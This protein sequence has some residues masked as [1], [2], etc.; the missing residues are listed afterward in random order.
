MDKELRNKL[1]KVLADK[2]V[3]TEDLIG[4]L[5]NSELKRLSEDYEDV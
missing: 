1:E 3:Y 5:S 4:E 2:V